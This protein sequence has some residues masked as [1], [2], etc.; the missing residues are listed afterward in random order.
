MFNISDLS[1]RFKLSGIAWAL[2]ILGMVLYLHFKKSWNLWYYFMISY[3]AI[4][5]GIIIIYLF[6]LLFNTSNSRFINTLKYTFIAISGPYL[7]IISI[8]GFTTKNFS[9]FGMYAVNF[10]LWWLLFS[11]S[12]FCTFRLVLGLALSHH[13]NKKAKY[14]QNFENSR[15]SL[16]N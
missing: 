12:F 8:Y 4:T 6:S 2:C 9:D 13:Q 10:L 7:L 11:V 3:L 14:Y 15:T 5:C 1:M 16:I